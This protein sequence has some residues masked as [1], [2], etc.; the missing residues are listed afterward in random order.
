MIISRRQLL[1]LTHSG[2]RTIDLIFAQTLSVLLT[3]TICTRVKSALS[4]VTK[5]PSN[6]KI[7]KTPSL[8]DSNGISH[9]VLLLRPRNYLS[10]EKVLVP[11]KLALESRNVRLASY[12]VN[13][14]EVSVETL[15]HERF[16]NILQT[17]DQWWSSKHLKQTCKSPSKIPAPKP[18]SRMREFWT[19]KSVLSTWK[20]PESSGNGTVN[21]NNHFL[22]GNVASE[23]AKWGWVFWF[24]MNLVTFG[25]GEKKRLGGVCVMQGCFVGSCVE[26]HLPA[27]VERKEKAPKVNSHIRTPFHFW[28]RLLWNEAATRPKKQKQKKKDLRCCSEEVVLLFGSRSLTSNLVFRHLIPLVFLLFLVT[29]GGRQIPFQHRKWRSREMASHAS[30]GCCVIG[31][32]TPGGNTSG[33][34]ESRRPSVVD[35]DCFMNLGVKG[36]WELVKVSFVGFFSNKK[37]CECSILG[38]AHHD[39]LVSMVHECKSRH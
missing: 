1:K 31:A 25:G 20:K 36:S 39:F 14:I 24:D 8:W 7:I 28:V 15:L 12:A 18:K 4:F 17:V 33:H 27:P 37:W 6:Q 13:G 29:V 5:P 2:L 23:R 19:T 34:H 16:T 10:R 35:T 26:T 30:A 9:Q 32:S 21:W 38:L 22:D 3:Y 11:L